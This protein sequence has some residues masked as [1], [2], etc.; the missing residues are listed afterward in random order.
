MLGQICY[1]YRNFTHSYFAIKIKDAQHKASQ[2]YE[3][4]YNMYTFTIAASILAVVLGNRILN[5]EIILINK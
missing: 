5:K 1:H 2:N 4:F 3:Q